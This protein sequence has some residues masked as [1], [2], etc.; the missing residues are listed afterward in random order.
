MI[1]TDSIT[2][3]IL[4]PV[5]SLVFVLLIGLGL[6]MTQNNKFTM[7]SMMNSKGEGIAD[8]FAKFSADYF[9]FFDFQDFENIVVAMETDPDIDHA[10]F[11]NS[12]F[13]PLTH[14][15]EVKEDLAKFLIMQRQ[16]KDKDGTLLGYM[17]I[18]FKKERLEKSLQKNILLVTLSLFAALILFSVIMYFLVKKLITNP[19]GR[20]KQMIQA[21]EMGHLGTRLNMEQLDEIGQ[22]ARSMDSFSE[23]LEY[24]VVGSLEQM[25]EGNLAFTLV[26]KD[27]RDIIRGALVKTSDGLNR[28]LEQIDA[29]ADQM[30]SGAG[31]VMDS[32]QSLS[33]G[34]T[35]QATS[36]EEISSS[37][38]QMAAQTR[39]NAENSDQANELAIKA[40]ESA[41]KGNLQMQ[42]MIT[43]MSEINEASQSISNI[44]KV[45]DEIAFQTNLLALNAAVEAARAG[46][47]GKGFAVVA[48]EVRSLAA[49]S[50][51]AA[52]ETAD[53]IEGSVHKAEN[54]SDIANQTAEALDEIAAGVIQ[55][56]D[57]I[58]EIASASTEQAEGIAQINRG[59]DQI[60]QVT[61]QNTALAEESA[62]AAEELAAQAADLHEMLDRFTLKR[63]AKTKTH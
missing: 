38:T 5:L 26:P 32:S 19:I 40:R 7:E 56:S 45:I 60:D 24:E 1:A 53:L 34:A 35:Q 43:A 21:L 55:V 4:L 30:A 57:L 59:L 6:F 10:A 17:Q 23:S 15:E 2:K 41:R 27:D 29:A 54:G 52:R 62:A 61:Q 8:I 3:K 58:K 47:H 36:L 14:V 13:E 20:T 25:A 49:R 33:Q 16:I 42:D 37:L 31:Q 11:F 9:A 63:K 28:V 46:R 39:T 44:I 18:A 51:K 50:A 12:D 22:M 48:E